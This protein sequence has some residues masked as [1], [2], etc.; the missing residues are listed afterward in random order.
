MPKN[1]SHPPSAD[2]R[3]DLQRILDEELYDRDA[4][5][6]AA[7]ATGPRGSARACA[8]MERRPHA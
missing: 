2:D 7:T 6:L 5:W 8:R 3:P 4:R 1:P